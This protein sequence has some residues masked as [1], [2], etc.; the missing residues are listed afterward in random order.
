MLKI[1]KLKLKSNVLLAPL[2]AVT[3]ASYRM[4][5][6]NYGAGLT[7]VP[8]MD[9]DGVMQA[10][11]RFNDYIDDERPVGGQLVGA[12]PQKLATAAKIIE[13]YSD[14]IDINFGCPDSAVVGKKAGSYHIK[15]PNKIHDII[16]SV[17]AAVK[18]PVTAK[19]R[20]GW[21]NQSINHIKVAKIIEDAGAD[22]ITVHGRTKEQMY[23]GKANWTAIKQVKDKLDI[24]VIGN[25]DVINPIT[26]KDMIEKTGVDG[27]MIGRAAMG[28]P[29]IFRQCNDYL[30]N[31]HYDEFSWNQKIEGFIEYVD[32]YKKYQNRY[33]FSELRTHALWFTKGIRESKVLRDSILRLED[34]KELICLLNKHMEKIK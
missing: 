15:H 17:K 30:A 25:G 12:S 32:Y 2:A 19:I 31:G 34:E 9:E 23:A 21:D 13:P 4:M 1:G 20:I 33:K 26:A 6:K 3:N 8:L 29:F 11:S 7:Y 16:S 27:V 18:L 14:L 5:C 22:A 28:N 10:F 24:P